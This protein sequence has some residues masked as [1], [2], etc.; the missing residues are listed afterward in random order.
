MAKDAREIVTLECSVC[1]EQITTTEKN[2]KLLK[3][4]LEFKKHCKRCRKHTLHKE[5][6]QKKGK[7]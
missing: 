3:E 5:V 7:K 1:K 4:K 2:T 6:K